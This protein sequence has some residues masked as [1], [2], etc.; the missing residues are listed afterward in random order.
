MVEAEMNFIARAG[1]NTVSRRSHLVKNVAE[2]DGSFMLH[3]QALHWQQRSGL[4]P[5]TR[6]GFLERDS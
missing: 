1:E 5:L 2:L 3:R 4:G 6:M